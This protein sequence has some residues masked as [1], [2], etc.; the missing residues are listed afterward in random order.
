MGVNW[1]AARRNVLGSLLIACIF[2]F[3]LCFNFPV[4]T[5]Q[6]VCLCLCCRTASG[7]EAVPASHLSVFILMLADSHQLLNSPTRDWLWNS[8][9]ISPCSPSEHSASLSLSLPILSFL[10]SV[11]TRPFIVTIFK[12]IVHACLHWLSLAV[13]YKSL[14]AYAGIYPRIWVRVKVYIG[15]D[16]CLIPCS[17]SQKH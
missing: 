8:P 17:T 9:L 5:R 7:C 3:L 15:A 13:F 14:R 16:K 4:Y 12:A 1:I 2:W 6:S 10:Q 11:E